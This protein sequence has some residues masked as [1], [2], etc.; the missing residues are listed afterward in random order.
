MLPCSNTHQR[1]GRGGPR[2]DTHSGWLPRASLKRPFAPQAG[3]RPRRDKRG[4]PNRPELQYC[5][6]DEGHATKLEVRGER[7]RLARPEPHDRTRSAELS[8]GAVKGPTRG[9]FKRSE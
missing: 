1:S 9:R 3:I 6:P 2:P 8:I 5:R 4:F 7:G